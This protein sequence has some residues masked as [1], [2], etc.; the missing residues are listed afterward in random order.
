MDEN[1]VI[2]AVCAYLAQRDYKILQQLPTTSKG[3]D[4]I[5]KHPSKLGRLLIEAKGG[6]SSRVGSNRYGKPYDDTQ[7]FDRVG[8]GVYTAVCLCSQHETTGD[9]VALA[10]P[11]LPLFRK[12]LSPTKPALLKLGI[13]VFLVDPTTLNVIVF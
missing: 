11:D 2:S 6:T 5:A 1:A 10:F 12:H 9:E 4:I 13:V 8:K 7:V 3:I